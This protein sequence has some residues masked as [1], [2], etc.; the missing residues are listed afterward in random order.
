MNSKNQM[1][2]EQEK[3]FKN[4]V[5]WLVVCFVGSLSALV[6]LIVTLLAIRFFT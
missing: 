3:Q 2:P 5:F 1:T 4:F 6:L